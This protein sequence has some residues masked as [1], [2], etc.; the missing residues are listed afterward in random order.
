MARLRQLHQDCDLGLGSPEKLSS[1]R[2]FLISAR[3]QL[4][5]GIKAPWFKDSASVRSRSGSL[6]GP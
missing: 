3:P 1:V 6:T 2:R 5:D 4:G